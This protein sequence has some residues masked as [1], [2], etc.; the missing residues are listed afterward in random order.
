LEDLENER[1]VKDEDG[2]LTAR[3]VEF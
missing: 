2:D 1:E 3:T